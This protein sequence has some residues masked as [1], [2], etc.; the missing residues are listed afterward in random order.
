MCDQFYSDVPSSFCTG[1]R[2]CYI[3]TMHVN[4]E[5]NR[6][7][8]STA[9]TDAPALCD[10]RERSRGNQP[11]PGEERRQACGEGFEGTPAE[12][13]FHEQVGYSE[14]AG[15]GGQVIEML[16]SKRMEE[17]INLGRHL[18]ID[19]HFFYWLVA[20]RRSTLIIESSTNTFL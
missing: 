5:S 1:W 4:M 9:G 3:D 20:N 7:Y 11:D 15:G 2:K 14:A 18:H 10:G 8:V 17:F 13:L 16:K 19:L 6:I 12:L